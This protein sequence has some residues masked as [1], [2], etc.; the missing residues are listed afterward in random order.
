MHKNY[1]EPLIFPPVKPD[2]T[3]ENITSN[4]KPSDH[5]VPVSVP[6]TSSYQIKQEY[7]TRVFRPFPESGIQQFGKWITSEDWTDMKSTTSLTETVSLFDEKI[8]M[9]VEEC[10]PLKNVKAPITDKPWITKE[11]SELSRQKHREYS[12][13]GKSKKYEELRKKFIKDE[14]IAVSKYKEKLMERVTSSSTNSGYAALKKMGARVGEES[15]NLFHLKHQEGLL[16]ILLTTS[17]QYLMNI[18][19]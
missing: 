6:M 16:K 5:S 9:K 2:N 14:K 3:S 7:R 18:N 1:T 13:H 15:N 11:L 10:L 8:H 19:L 12:K 4:A 17:Q